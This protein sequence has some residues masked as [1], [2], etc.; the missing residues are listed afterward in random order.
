MSFLVFRLDSITIYFK[1][2]FCVRSIKAMGQQI[3]GYFRPAPGFQEWISPLRMKAK[4]DLHEVKLEYFD[5]A[6]PDNDKK[7]GIQPNMRRHKSSV[8]EDASICVV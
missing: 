7:I 6:L 3:C 1:I 2:R 4:A 8:V 5:M